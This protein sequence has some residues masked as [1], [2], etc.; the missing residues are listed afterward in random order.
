MA[1]SASSFGLVCRGTGKENGEWNSKGK[2]KGKEDGKGKGRSMGPRKDGQS[3]PK[4]K[5]EDFLDLVGPKKMAKIL[6]VLKSRAVEEGEDGTRDEEDEDE[7]DEDED[8]SKGEEEDGASGSDSGARM[9]DDEVVGVDGAGATDH[10]D[11]GRG[12]YVGIYVPY[13]VCRGGSESAHVPPLTGR[14]M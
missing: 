4:L 2:G 11:G 13:V 10:R 5:L 8:G 3:S 12:S 6:R 9:N 1:K 7:E 14:N